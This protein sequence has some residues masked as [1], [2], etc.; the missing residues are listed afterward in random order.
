MAIQIPVG[1]GRTATIQEPTR[2]QFPSNLG[3]AVEFTLAHWVFTVLKIAGSSFGTFFGGALTGFLETI[4]PE[5][6]IY[7]APLIDWLLATPNLPAQLKTFFQQLRNPQH[8]AGAV[9]LQGLAGSAANSITSSFVGALLSPVTYTINGGMRPY[10]PTPGETVAMYYRGAINSETYLRYM[11]DNGVP[12]VAKT[13]LEQLVRQR[14]DVG[15]L[16]ELAVRG[17]WSWDAVGA[18]LRARGMTGDDIAGLRL[19]GQKLLE[20]GASITAWLRGDVSE[21]DVRSRLQAQGYNSTD[22]DL[23]LKQAKWIPGPSDLIRMAVREAFDDASSARFQHDA[24]FP[25]P[26]GEWL[27]KT[28]GSV[29]WARRYWR[30]HWELPSLTQAFEMLHR[31]IM[32]LDDVKQLIKMQDLAPY[33]R[34]K[35]VQL[36]YNPLTRV[37]VRRM[38]RLGV[39]DEAGVRKAYADLGYNPT[40]AEQ[41]TRFT[42]LYEADQ[43]DDDAKQKKLAQ[44]VIGNAYKKGLL[45]RGE[46]ETRLRSLKYATEDIDL[47]LDLVDANRLVDDKPDYSS[48]Y[49][50]DVKAI[51]EDAYS[52]RV[53]DRQTAA[54][55]LQTAGFVQSEVM[56]LLDTLDVG[57]EMARA[58]AQIEAV[59]KRYLSG[60]IDSTEATQLLGQ[61]G[62]S[63]ARQQQV[64]SAWNISRDVKA[65]R[66]S[67][68]QYRA[69]VTAGLI[70]LD[71]YKATMAQ[72][73]YAPQ[74]VDLLGR[75]LQAK[76]APEES[77]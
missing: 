43:D 3:G 18:E 70:T 33:W 75:M 59:G 64:I 38:Y 1:G 47:L 30:S 20:V 31:G 45:T 55:M 65:R 42:I 29:E 5:L 71:D 74:D 50:K 49:V 25:A 7:T 48:E 37:D 36:S 44:S 34:D 24:E 9:I 53:I 66:L 58:D 62:V 17:K 21:G 19:L 27:A 4:E 35:L 2:A 23:L 39:L 76:L 26:F 68:S 14:L 16:I 32:S 72:L 57:D 12:D 41:M 46:A 22:V 61:I 6:V 13:G 69:A 60:A 28:G 51:V 56:L 77:E 40:H 10:R 67:E 52:K 8:Q 15:S 54:S 63:G 11:Q 73:G